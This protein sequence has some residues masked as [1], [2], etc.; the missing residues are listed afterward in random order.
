MHSWMSGL[1]IVL[2]IAFAGTQL[3]ALKAKAVAF[4][5]S[6]TFSLAPAFCQLLTALGN[7]WECRPHY[8]PNFT[9]FS[10]PPVG[11]WMGFIPKKRQKWCLPSL[12]L[13]AHSLSLS[14]SCMVIACRS[15]DTGSIFSHK[16][17]C[18]TSSVVLRIFEC[19]SPGSFW[20]SAALFHARSSL[21]LLNIR[22]QLRWYFAL[23]LLSVSSMPP[24]SSNQ[25][26]SNLIGCWLIAW[27]SG[28]F[29]AIIE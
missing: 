3:C 11:N 16:K 22:R 4:A 18:C 23:F 25:D 20:M 1:R 14:F 9:F 15:L 17:H 2:I 13:R 19:P 8:L 27:K 6:T 24:P 26:M 21:L 10:P 12:R 5:S 29:V 7:W 28:T